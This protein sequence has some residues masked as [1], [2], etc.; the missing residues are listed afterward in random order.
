MR[1]LGRPSERRILLDG[2]KVV[3]QRRAPGFRAEV[4]DHRLLIVGH[5]LL[6]PLAVLAFASQTFHV[7]RGAA[8]DDP[9]AQPVCSLRHARQLRQGEAE[10]TG[11]YHDDADDMQVYPEVG[12][13]R[14]REP[15]DRAGREEEDA[16]ASAQRSPADWPGPREPAD[17]PAH[18]R[19]VRWQDRVPAMRPA[20]SPEMIRAMTP[21]TAPS[22]R[23]PLDRVHV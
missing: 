10:Q 3:G 17:I 12:P 4:P 13:R 16:P 2:E 7:P 15:E 18:R 5:R 21:M 22:D 19:A 6:I 14:E 8:G 1:L 11:A 23:R 20:T 9:A